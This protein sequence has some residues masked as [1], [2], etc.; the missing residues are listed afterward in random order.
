M[1]SSI[2]IT[3]GDPAGIGP[4]ITAKT[5]LSL[6][7]DSLSRVVVVGDRQTFEDAFRIVAPDRPFSA[8][9]I[10]FVQIPQ[11]GSVPVGEISAEGGEAA[12][13]AVAGAV[14]LA[15]VGEVGC[16]VTAPLNKAA[17]HRAGHYFDGHT[18]LLAHLTGQNSGFMLLASERLNTIHVSTHVSLKVAT[19]RVT[20][21]RILDV[22]QAARAH[23]ISLGISEPRIAVA[24]L[25]PHC[26]EGGLFGD[27][28]ALEIE[29]GVALCRK[30]GWDVSGPI[31]GDTIFYR[32]ARGEFDVVVAQYHDQ[33]HIPIKLI[34]FDS[35]VNVTLGLPIRR[36]SVDHGTAF[37]I[38]GTGKADATN[39][40][41][42]IAYA[43]KM[44]AGA[45]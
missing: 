33:G 17:L 12:Y 20:A 15:L 40:S 8:E 41:C 9:N 18:G 25:N 29:P 10:R 35:A 39:M 13:Q 45:G 23:F 42:A 26:S 21:S 24:G 32:A 30:K 3:L 7:S 36:T 19:D 14:E 37:D 31:S 27:E 6:D 34:A 11:Q 43:F 1:S 5:L 4:E 28:E 44:L 16:I 2:A 38:A 22:V